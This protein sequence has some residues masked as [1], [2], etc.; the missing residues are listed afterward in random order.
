MKVFFAA[1]YILLAMLW[2]YI[3]YVKYRPPSAPVFTAP[4]FLYAERLL[5]PPNEAEDMLTLAQ[6]CNSIPGS[7][8][9]ANGV[10]MLPPGEIRT[11]G[12]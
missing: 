12:R 9:K 7:T 3:G 2:G 8:L 10:C 11:F 6:W 4:T 5:H 1:W